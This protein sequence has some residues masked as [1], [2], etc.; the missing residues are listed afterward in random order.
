MLFR[1]L[2]PLSPLAL[3]ALL[4]FL[5]S[6]GDVSGPLLRPPPAP[7]LLL[8]LPFQI[9]SNLLFLLF[10]P[11]FFSLPLLL[12]PSLP[13]TMRFPARWRFLPWRAPSQPAAAF[14]F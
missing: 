6:P 3:T 2:S 9:L 11:L 5:L 12:S 14:L 7:C 13:I 4:L 10:L 8:F 1:L